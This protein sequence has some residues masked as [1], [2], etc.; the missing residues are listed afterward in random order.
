VSN[1]EHQVLKIDNMPWLLWP[2]KNAK[3]DWL[4][5]LGP[6][7]CILAVWTRD[8]LEE[9]GQPYKKMQLVEVS[10]LD[11]KR[12]DTGKYQRRCSH[13]ELPTLVTHWSPGLCDFRIEMSAV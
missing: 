3:H 11:L 13:G 10:G 12:N 5:P 9:V 2:A 4:P 6:P 7:V 8:A 1:N